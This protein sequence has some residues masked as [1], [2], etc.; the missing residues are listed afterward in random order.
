MPVTP[1]DLLGT[2]ALTRVV[3]DHRTGERRDVSGTATLE[4]ESP[5]R[6]RWTEEGTMS[7]PGHDVPIGRTLFVVRTGGT[8]EV[9]FEDGRAFHP[10]TVGSPVEHP[11]APDLYRGDVEAAGDPVETWTVTWDA[12]GP[13]KDYRMVTVYSDRR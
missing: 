13:G 2:W 12:S 10:W 5:G 7:W 11:C 1:D 3:V 4:A 8:W 9:R 6:V